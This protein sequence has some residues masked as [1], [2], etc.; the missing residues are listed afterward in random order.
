MQQNLLQTYICSA[1][2]QSTHTTKYQ[3]D[4][5]WSRPL[6]FPGFRQ[7]ST[8]TRC[9]E[10][11]IFSEEL[12]NNMQFSGSAFWH[13]SGLVGH[14]FYIPVYLGSLY[15]N[16]QSFSLWEVI[17]SFTYWSRMTAT[18]TGHCNTYLYHNHS[19]SCQR[20][21]LIAS[22]SYSS[23]YYESMPTVQF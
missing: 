13:I 7:H 6:V 17:I 16:R 21:K 23:F 9:Q 2:A 12:Q 19:Q 8:Y 20:E 10:V 1:P 14:L 18:F 11:A 5:L 3:Q 4:L 22:K 15:T